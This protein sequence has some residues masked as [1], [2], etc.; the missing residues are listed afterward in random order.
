LTGYILPKT[1]DEEE[2]ENFGELSLHKQDNFMENFV[3]TGLSAMLQ[4]AERDDRIEGI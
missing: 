1:T 3:S 2:L 4:K